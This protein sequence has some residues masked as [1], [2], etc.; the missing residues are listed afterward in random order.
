[1]RKLI[2]ATL[3]LLALAPPA[4]AGDLVAPASVPPA[5]NWTG[6]YAGGNAGGLWGHQHWVNETQGGDFFGYSLGEHDQGSWIAGLQAGCDYQ[7]SSGFVVGVAGDYSWTDAEGS[8]ASARET[9]VFYHSDVDSLASVT[10]RLGYGWDRLLGY[11]KGGAAWQRDDYWATTLILGTA[12]TASDTRS[13]WMVG[14]GGEYAFTEHW[15]GFVEHD[16]YN[17]GD[18]K[19][20]LTPRVA[21]LRHAAVDLEE[22]TNVMRAGLNYHF[23]GF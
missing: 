21:G 5:S 1:L 17:F 12:Y 14:G 15:S 19:I 23:G 16:Y 9:G 10:G 13:G 8:H 2:L 3:A 4:L 22:T 7:T 11:V 6:C 20:G 18:P